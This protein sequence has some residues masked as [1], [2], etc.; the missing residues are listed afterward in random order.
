M[1]G[2]RPGDQ[3]LYV[4]RNGALD[5]RWSEVRPKLGPV[6]FTSIKTLIR[7]QG[8]GDLY[9]IYL[10]AKRDKMP[11]RLAYIPSDFD[12]EPEEDFDPKY[13]RALFDLAYELSRDGYEWATSPP[14]VALP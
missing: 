12:V 6:A 13:M 2:D 14:G 5:P 10:G 4:I 7:T 3:T 11:Y 1:V 8:M 9:R